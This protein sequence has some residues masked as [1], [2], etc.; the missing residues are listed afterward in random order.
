M[1]RSAMIAQFLLGIGIVYLSW[2]LIAME[3]NYRRAASMGIPLVRLP[4]DPKNILWMVLEPSIW[5]LLDHLPFDWG[6]FRRYSRRGWH[7]HDKAR[8]HL[9]YG[10]VWALVTPCDIYV[11]VVDSVAITDIFHRRGDF[12]RPN[13]LYSKLWDYERCEIGL[14]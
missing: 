14:T 3:I 8:S 10:P 9:Q 4:V 13:N 6:T 7:F 5:R 12:L 1:P 11:H 2:S